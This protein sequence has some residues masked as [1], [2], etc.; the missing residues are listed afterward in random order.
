MQ[1]K[2]IQSSAESLEEYTAH[3]RRISP[4][5]RIYKRYFLSPV[6]YWNARR[7]GPRVIEIGCGTGSG[8]LGAYSER[9]SGLDIN[10]YSI[11]LCRAAGLQA[12]LIESDGTFPVPVATFDTCVLDN[13][14]EHIEDPRATLDECHR[15]TSER[16]GLVI[17]VPGIRGFASDPDHKRFLGSVDLRQL[18]DRWQFKSVFSMPFFLSSDLLSSLVRQY[19]LV[20]VYQKKLPSR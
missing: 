7:F 15:I 19:C 12:T 16:G 13:V 5:G 9:V 11:A 2:S 18:D 20:A 6:L 1:K 10:P 8:V 14:L 3:L 4:L 17:A